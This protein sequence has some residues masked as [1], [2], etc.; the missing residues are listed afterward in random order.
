VYGVDLGG[1]NVLVVTI[2]QT[3]LVPADA[4]A[5]TR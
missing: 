3:P 5:S 1:G 4:V 2:S